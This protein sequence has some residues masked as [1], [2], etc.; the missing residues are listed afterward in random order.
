MPDTGTGWSLP[1]GKQLSRKGPGGAGYSSMIP[2][3]YLALMQPH[4]ENSVQF[5]AP[6]K[7]KDVKELE[8]AQ[9]RA[10]QLVTGL[11]PCPVNKD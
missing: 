3:L 5:W 8:C 4:L 9:R 2:L 11:E 6:Q 10:L 1:A 7:K